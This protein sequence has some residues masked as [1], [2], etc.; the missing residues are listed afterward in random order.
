MRTALKVCLAIILFPLSIPRLC[1]RFSAWV[2][3]C[4]RDF[5]EDL[6]D[7]LSNMNEAYGGGR[8]LTDYQRVEKL[9]KSFVRRDLIY[10]GK[11]DRYTARSMLSLADFYRSSHHFGEAE[12]WYSRAL[13]TIEGDKDLDPGDKKMIEARKKVASFMLA[14]CRYDAAEEQLSKAMSARKE[15]TPAELADDLNMMA[16]IRLKR[17]NKRGALDCLLQEVRIRE[18]MTSG[19]PVDLDRAYSDIAKLHAELGEEREAAR[20][21][22]KANMLIDLSISERALGDEHFALAKPLSGLAAIYAAEGNAPRAEYLRNWESLVRLAN[23]VKGLD[24]P[25]LPR[26]LED[27]AALYEKRASHADPTLAFHARTRA[28]RIRDKRLNR[29]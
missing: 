10:F 13:R 29:H 2:D 9:L 28:R 8:V 16:T 25:N 4:I 3:E 18:D 26:D 7:T 22:D 17:D 6:P 11:N 15:V 20:V 19:V 12:T 1:R 5:V 23:K 21:R 24:Y 27:L 14:Y